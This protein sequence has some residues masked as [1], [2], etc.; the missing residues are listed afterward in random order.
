M[1]ISYVRTDPFVLLFPK[2][3][4]SHFSP[5]MYSYEWLCYKYA[6][7][8]VFYKELGD[9]ILPLD[10]CSLLNDEDYGKSNCEEVVTNA[11]YNLSTYL[12]PSN[13]FIYPS[14]RGERG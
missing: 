1:C 5:S 4:S 2:E 14:E 13:P 8:M 11:W 3:N 12:S 9:D 6:K 7:T 10:F